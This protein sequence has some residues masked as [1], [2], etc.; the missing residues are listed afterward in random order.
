MNPLNQ[1]SPAVSPAVR[2][3]LWAWGLW[4]AYILLV[5]FLSFQQGWREADF[6][7]A[8]KFNNPFSSGNIWLK[9]TECMRQTGAWLAVCTDHGLDPMAAHSAGDDSGH[10]LFLDI[11]AKFSDRKIDLS[12]IVHLNMLINL[13]GIGLLAGLSFYQRRYVMAVIL[14]LFSDGVFYG[15]DLWLDPFPHSSFAGALA[16]GLLMPLVLMEI[17]N[18]QGPASGW[19]KAGLLALGCLGLGLAAL[20]REPIGKMALVVSSVA[21]GVIIWQAWRNQPLDY[22][23]GPDGVKGVYRLSSYGTLVG[24]FLLV[25]MAW[26]TPRWVLWARDVSFPMNNTQQLQAH[27]S[28]HTLYLGLGDVDNR[29]FPGLCYGLSPTELAKDRNQADYL[30]PCKPDNNFGIVWDDAYGEKMAKSLDP[31]VRYASTHYYELLWGLYIHTML[32]D[33]L[34]TIRIYSTKAWALLHHRLTFTPLP[35]YGWMLAVGF[36]WI[37]AERRK[38]WQ[39]LGLGVTAGRGFLSV[40]SGFGLL[41]IAQGVLASTMEVYSQPL[42]VLAMLVVGFGAEICWRLSRPNSQT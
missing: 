38:L 33:P 42:A 18:A 13:T 14:P 30:L 37:W 5:M 9:T 11:L 21:I 34:E 25:L 7:L 28:A 12:D 22:G 32:S 40:V 6:Q 17:A 1:N 23:V 31:T 27:G 4:L 10:A 36:L 15:F 20:L 41:I 19:R 16:L 29:H 24:L 26:S 3:S 35:I 8:G 2:P 39:S